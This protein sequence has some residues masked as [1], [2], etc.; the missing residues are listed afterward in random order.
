MPTLPTVLV[1]T[2]V[3]VPPYS[4]RGLRMSLQP[5]SSSQNLRRTVNGGL[6]DLSESAF[7][8][9]A[10]TITGSDIDPPAIESV[11]PGLSVTVHSIVEL[12]C[13]APTEMPTEEEATD[14]GLEREPVPG[15]IR[16]A[17]GFIFYR[18]VLHMR[19]VGFEV[20]RD[21]WGNT[22]SWT[23]QLEEE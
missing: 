18:P 22:H 17:D 12:S 16:E 11:W 10:A 3:G 8:K 2:G 9:Y 5:I 6:V 21:E 13:E 14:L 23:M 15:S 19:V 1:L 20:N 4:A 7:R